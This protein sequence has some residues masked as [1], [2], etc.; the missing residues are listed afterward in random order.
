[1][2]PS[3]CEVFRAEFLVACLSPAALFHR[4]I[5]RATCSARRGAD[6]DEQP[7]RLALAQPYGTEASLAASCRSSCAARS[8]HPVAPISSHRR[9]ASR[10]WR[11]WPASSPS[12]R[13]RAA[14]STRTGA[15][16]AGTRLLNDR[17]R[18]RKFCLD[19]LPRD[20]PFRPRSPRTLQD[21]TVASAT[22]SR[23]RL[24]PR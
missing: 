20:W 10:N 1:M 22:K 18:P 21:G 12:T 14:R 4:P 24:K 17:I 3:I 8:A 2:K 15:F 9:C 6:L 16:C 5:S 13:A 19:R 7:V 11:S 23:L